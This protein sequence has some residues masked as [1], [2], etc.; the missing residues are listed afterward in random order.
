MPPTY[1]RNFLS[2]VIFDATY[3]VQDE[4]KRVLNEDLKH[5]ILGLLPGSEFKEQ[6][7]LSFTLGGEVTRSIDSI[8]NFIGPRFTVSISSQNLKITDNK[9]SEYSEFHPIIINIYDLFISIYKPE[10][11]RISMRYINNIY[12][13]TGATYDF[14]NLIIPELISPTLKFK[15]ISTLTRSNGLMILRDDNTSTKFTYGFT[16]KEF[17][18]PIIRREFILDYDCETTFN[19][20][21]KIAEKLQIIRARINFL[22]ESSIRPGLKEHMNQVK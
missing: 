18:S 21:E 14:E 6:K 11:I 4:I 19:P 9:Y 17:P 3:K 12:F 8:W 22:F 2:K 20:G 16:N 10:V 1:Q 15:D 5:I 13:N 7:S